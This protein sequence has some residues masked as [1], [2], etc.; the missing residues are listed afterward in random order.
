MKLEAFEAIA[1]QETGLVLMQITQ[2]FAPYNKND[3]AGF[4]PHDAHRLFTRRAAVPVTKEGQP[5][6]L[7]A[8]PPQGSPEPEPVTVEIPEN[9]R[10][11]HRLQK[12]ILAKRIT[13]VEGSMTEA[14]ADE[15]LA[16]EVE[17][18]TQHVGK[19]DEA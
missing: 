12:V 15:I 19:Q 18:R 3:L 17:R 11:I 2:S 14:A 7:S 16:A 4:P 6:R 9:W 13:G 5:I 10:E 1:N 8:D